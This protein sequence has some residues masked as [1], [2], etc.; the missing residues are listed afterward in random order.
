MKKFGVWFVLVIILLSCNKEE[1]PG[2]FSKITGTLVVKELNKDKQV[3]KSYL[4]AGED[5]Y[6]TYGSNAYF[7][8]DAETSNN[9]FFQFSNLTA[10]D[11]TIWYYT[12]DTSAYT[13][14]NQTFISK[15]VSVGKK[16][17]ISLDTLFTYD[18]RDIDDGT[19]TISGKVYEV[20]YKYTSSEPYDISDVLSTLPAAEVDVYIVYGDDDVYFDR[21]RTNHDGTFIF[22][23]LIKGNYRI[24]LY[25]DNINGGMYESGS[26]N[27][28]EF[29]ETTDL[30]LYRDVT[31]SGDFE[32]ETVEDFYTED[33]MDIEDGNSSITGTIYKIQYWTSAI[34]PYD[35]NDIKDITPAEELDVYIVY[36]DEASFFERTRTNYNGV[37]EFKD[38]I[39]GNYRV[40]VYSKDI[41]GGIYNS[42]SENVIFNENSLGSY[43]LVIYRDVTITGKYEK[44]NVT[45]MYIEKN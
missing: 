30:I 37:F 27:V 42:S 5:I 6:I 34:P 7:D 9:G 1:G 17:T 43:D 19:A 4:A 24:Y 20:N 35:T 26:A 38:L 33:I 11:Y 8:D 36:E 13:G 10:G 32:N 14:D 22:K 18:I 31:I 40:F 16:E 25:S 15:K 45:D 23:N 44:H 2:G 28:I 3:I 39:E 29:S 21:T 12:D 41:L